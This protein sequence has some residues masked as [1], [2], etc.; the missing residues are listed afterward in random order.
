VFYELGS[1]SFKQRV[2]RGV[3]K[4]THT[5]LVSMPIVIRAVK[6]LLNSEISQQTSVLPK[7]LLGGI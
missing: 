1:E 7:A 4:C 3:Q 6:L 5:A 2:Q